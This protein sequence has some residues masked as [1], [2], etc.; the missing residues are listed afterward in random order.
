VLERR[1]GGGGEEAARKI[2]GMRAIIVKLWALD[3]E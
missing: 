3:G 2:P 1:R